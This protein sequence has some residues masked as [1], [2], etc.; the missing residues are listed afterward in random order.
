MD[1]AIVGYRNYEN[2][3][4]FYNIVNNIINNINLP[5][6]KI[7][8]GGC[9]GVDNLA[10]KYS[11]DKNIK[12]DEYKAEW[13]KY[14]KKA[15]PMRNEIIVKKCSHI[16]LFIHPLSKGTKNTLDLAIKYK[17]IYFVVNI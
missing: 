5:I 6:N 16:I 15:G 12:F 9:K 13:D 8:S 1:L 2:Y 11:N 3:N 17:K 7:I 4:D 14:G 10:K